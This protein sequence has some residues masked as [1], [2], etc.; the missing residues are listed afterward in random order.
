M[1]LEELNQFVFFEFC[2]SDV[3]LVDSLSNDWL[4]TLNLEIEFDII[5]DGALNWLGGHAFRLAQ[6]LQIF[7]KFRAGIVSNETDNESLS[8]ED[9]TAVLFLECMSELW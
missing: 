4:L 5:L 6:C 7:N 1:F 8:D 3:E 2:T 9:D